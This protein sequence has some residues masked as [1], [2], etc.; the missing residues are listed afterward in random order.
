MIK[1]HRLIASVFGVGYVSKGGGTLAALLCCIFW[2]ALRVDPFGIATLTATGVLAGVG[3]WSSYAVEPGW[4]KDSSKVVID[5]VAGMMVTLVFVP[6]GV[7]YVLSGF[8][9]FRFFDIVKP[10]F[11]KKTEQLPGGWG[12]MMDDVQAGLYAN[13]VLQLIIFFK[14]F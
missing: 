14:L 3:V 8:L 7:Q 12:V 4:G 6:V 10:L 1:V 13:G 5:E 11:I 9:L 2:Y